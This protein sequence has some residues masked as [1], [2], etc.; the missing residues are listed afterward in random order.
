MQ[1]HTRVIR[2]CAVSA[3]HQLHVSG[4]FRQRDKRHPRSRRLTSPCGWRVGAGA[5]CSGAGPAA[6]PRSGAPL[7]HIRRW[8]PPSSSAVPW[9]GVQ[10]Q[11]LLSRVGSG[12]DLVH[13][14]PPQLA[15]LRQHYLALAG[16][17]LPGIQGEAHGVH[18]G[19]AQGSSSR[20]RMR[21]SASDSEFAAEPAQFPSR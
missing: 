3:C 12:A 15:L 5:G 21:L 7:E 9:A 18:Q 4:L 16:A 1:Q 8:P 11:V 19:A 10:A 13:G 2:G 14:D 20:W 17:L 6:A